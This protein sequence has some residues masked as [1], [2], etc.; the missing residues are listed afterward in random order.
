MVVP[1]FLKD[2]RA[3]EGLP[4]RIMVTVIV[5][6][7]ILSLIGKAAFD[8]IGEAKEKKLM[9]E[10]DMIEKRAAVMYGQGGARDTGNPGDLSGTMESVRVKIPDNAAFVVF[11]EMPGVAADA[12]TDNVYYYVLNNGRMQAKSSIARFTR[13]VL[14]P[15]EYELTLELVRYN[16]GTFVEIKGG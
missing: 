3:A 9:G 15:G 4:M 12:R 16:N 10:L 1:G 14:Y 5:F 6:G 2:E 7:V 8:F 11:G 13:T